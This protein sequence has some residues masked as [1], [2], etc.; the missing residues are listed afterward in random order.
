MEEQ[1]G[2]RG[3]SKTDTTPDTDALKNS[4]KEPPPKDDEETS[5]PLNEELLEVSTQKVNE[6][7]EE[8]TTRERKEEAGEASTD[9]VLEAPTQNVNEKVEDEITR[10]K[11]EE[12]GEASTDEGNEDDS[13]ERKK[14][15]IDAESLR[16]PADL[17][18]PGNGLTFNTPANKEESTT[19]PSPTK[20]KGMP[21]SP[22]IT[23]LQEELPRPRL[24][25]KCLHGKK[26]ETPDRQE[27]PSAIKS[28]RTGQLSIEDSM[29][30]ASST[31]KPQKKQIP[32]SKLAAPKPRIT[33]DN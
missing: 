1:Q 12:V 29:R 14:T 16:L 13:R 22:T 7:V 11:K 32:K 19:E 4:S 15:K 2:S 20:A 5:T 30:N 17:Q 18:T 28:K 21:K 10:E 33:F 26:Q 8:E 24:Q 25:K 31:K 3:S 27:V 9:E 6:E 23:K